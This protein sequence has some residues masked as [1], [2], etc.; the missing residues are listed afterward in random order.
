MFDS[1]ETTAPSRPII[2]GGEPLSI[3]DTPCRSPEGLLTIATL[4]TPLRRRHSVAVGLARRYRTLGE[5]S[6]ESPATLQTLCGRASVAA[7]IRAPVACANAL[8]KAQTTLERAEMG[9]IRVITTFENDYPTRLGELEDGPALIYIKG[10]LN[11][12]VRVVACVGTRNPTRFGAV[13]TQRITTLLASQGWSIVSGLALGVDTIAHRAAL[14]AKGHTVAVVGHGLDSVYPR[15]NRRL[16]RAIVE[17]GGAL[18][19]EEPP[20]VEPTPERL[21][22]RDRLQS[23]LSAAVVVLQSDL[24]G[25]SM[26]TVRSAIRQGRALFVPVPTGSHALEPKSRA[27]L[28][29][30][31]PPSA[32]LLAATGIT[33]NLAAHRRGE[34]AIS[35]LASPIRGFGDYPLFLAALEAIIRG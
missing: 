1:T 23:G 19:S 25:G 20:G 7:A 15:S 11:R 16:A 2:S 14:H 17:S 31:K 21:V 6:A 22:L 10:E 3:R 29:L 18:L 35:P 5:L 24:E 13:V 4:L 33:G 26:H 27:L 30:V 8:D 12:G 32:S 28:E 9:S 34:R